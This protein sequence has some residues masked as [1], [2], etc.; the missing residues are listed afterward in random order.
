MSPEPRSIARVLIVTGALAMLGMAA[1]ATRADDQ[2]AGGSLALTARDVG[3]GL[4]FGLAAFAATGPMRQRLWIAA[5][6]LAWLAGSLFLPALSLHQAVLAIVLLAAPTGAIRSRPRLILALVGGVLIAGEILPQPAVA[7][8]FL[9]VAA[10]VWVTAEGREANTVF[11]CCAGILVALVL[12]FGWWVV[13]RGTSASTVLAAYEA[14]LVLVAIGLSAATWLDARG[15]ARLADRVLGGST[16]AGLEGL[17]Q[18][19]AGA[20]HDGDLTVELVDPARAESRRGDRAPGSRWT[21]LPVLDGQEVVAVVATR[22]TALADGPTALAVAT[23]VRLTVANLRLNQ[24]Q[25]RQA[26]EVE[27]SRVRLLAAVDRERQR[28]AARL[29]E[30]AGDH[31]QRALA[32][33]AAANGDGAAGISDLEHLV[34]SEIAAASAEVERIVA[35]VPPTA[36]GSGRLASAITALAARSPV[37]VSLELADDAAADAPIETALF[38]VCSEALTNIAKHS[39][40][41]HVDI[42]LSCRPGELAM[43]IRDNGQGGAN[44]EGSGIRGLRDRMATLGG[45]VTVSSSPGGGTVIG[46]AVPTRET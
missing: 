9:V 28:V 15:R 45:S 22:S 26:S 37:P 33:L 29:R 7:G 12:A 40:A 8:Y 10:V 25:A 4:V 23:A 18:V 6:G 19:L 38:Y 34:E 39:G 21:S 43:A 5:V 31:L 41:T 24:A 1:L 20:L 27:A 11:S 46:A 35:G 42:R 32:G 3:V 36:L 2:A 14:I 30:D 13:P 44:G 17:R 16:I